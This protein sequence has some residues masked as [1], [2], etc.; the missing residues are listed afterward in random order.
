[1]LRLV[2]N[3]KD[4]DRLQEIQSQLICIC[5]ELVRFSLFKDPGRK[6]FLDE[7]RSGAILIF[8]HMGE[9]LRFSLNIAL[10]TG[11]HPRTAA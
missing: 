8:V 11:D 4:F 6:P 7:Y 9:L 2:S 3:D 10:V 5:E 1:M